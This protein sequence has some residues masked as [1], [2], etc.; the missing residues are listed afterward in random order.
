RRTARHGDVL[1]PDRRAGRTVDH[2]VRRVRADVARSRPGTCRYR[3][4]LAEGI[5]GRLYPALARLP[6]QTQPGLANAF[7]VPRGPGRV[8][9]CRR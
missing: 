4:E 8:R 6:A 3:C 1:R 5:A 7:D 9:A 2:R